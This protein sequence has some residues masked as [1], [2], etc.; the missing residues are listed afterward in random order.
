MLASRDAEQLAAGAALFNHPWRFVRGV[1]SL[2]FLP[3]AD[4]PELAFA[5]RSNVGKSSLINALVNQRGLARTSQAPGRTQELN[6]FERLGVALFLV[7]M[8]GYGFA[9]APKVRVAAWTQLV[10]EYLRGR[11]T[12][13][14][15]FLLIDA[16]HGLMAG[17]R[18]MMA[19]MDDSGV[20]YQAVLSKADKLTPRR[21][22]TVVAA[23]DSVLCHHA[24]ARQGILATSAETGLGIPELRAEIAALAAAHG[25]THRR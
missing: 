2:D 15:V 19:L 23:S 12:L 10:R 17:D 13:L 7:D 18:D 1:P 14:R 20:S 4:R 6:F 22:G 25:A 8:P 21:L 11:P 3:S 5:G 24:A 9:K 16:R